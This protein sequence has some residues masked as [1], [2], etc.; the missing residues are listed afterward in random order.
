MTAPH[1]ARCAQPV[2]S[3]AGV[4]LDPYAGARARRWMEARPPA[5]APPGSPQSHRAPPAAPCGWRRFFVEAIVA[6][7]IGGRADAGGEGERSVDRADHFG[8]GDVFWSL[9]EEVAAGS[10]SQTADNAALL[11]IEQNLFEKFPRH[12]RPGSDIGIMIG[13][14]SPCSASTIKACRA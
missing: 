3:G 6:F 12:A 2:S 4:W 5:S 10:S 14:L 11:E 9:P 13:S 8:K 7:V 1:L